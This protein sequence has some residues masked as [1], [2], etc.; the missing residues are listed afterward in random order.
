MD[1]RASGSILLAQRT[2][3]SVCEETQA[4]MRS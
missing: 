1:L 4:E 2:E 3:L